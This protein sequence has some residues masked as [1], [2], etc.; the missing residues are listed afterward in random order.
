M[1]GILSLEIIFSE[2]KIPGIFRDI[3]VIFLSPHLERE[4][5]RVDAKHRPP[6]LI[7]NGQRDVPRVEIDIRVPCA[8]RAYDG[9]GCQNTPSKHTTEAARK[10]HLTITICNEFIRIQG[11]TAGTHQA[12]TAAQR[13]AITA[14]MSTAEQ[15]ARVQHSSTG[16]RAHH[17]RSCHNTSSTQMGQTTGN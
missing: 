17:E 7:Q 2:Y 1:S 6:V 4:N 9:R 5:H 8:T 16:P 3:V 13:N 12:H 11:V 10:T 14:T 15:L